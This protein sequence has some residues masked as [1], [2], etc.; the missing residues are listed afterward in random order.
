MNRKEN[1]IKLSINK[2]NN[3]YDY[4]K[5]DYINNK[6][7][8]CI[9]CPEHGEFW[10]IPRD[11]QIGNGCPYCSGKVTF[12]LT[13][14]QFIK[15]AKKIHGNEYDYNNV[16]YINAFTNVEI[17]C[18]K[19]GSFKQRASNH[20][21]GKGC[22]KCKCSKLEK[23]LYDFL[24]NNN[25][26]FVKEYSPS[27]LPNKRY[28]FYLPDFKLLIEC[29]GIQHFYKSYFNEKYGGLDKQIYSD[30]L[31]YNKTKQNKCDIIYFYEDRK[32]KKK[33][34]LSNPI[35]SIYTKDNLLHIK[36]LCSFF[37]SLHCQ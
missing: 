31:K 18:H 23:K 8:V 15:K 28:D 5:V 34:V 1:F 37:G 27:W 22:P 14:A 33:G 9:I 29:Q 17:V 35:F 6:T 20:L 24:I 26:N 30:I 4:S 13:T 25:I 16:N 19:H 12:K 3:K 32:I 11:H 2:H 21:Q 10:Q 36:Q 7:K